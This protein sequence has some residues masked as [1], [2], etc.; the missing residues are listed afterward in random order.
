MDTLTPGARYW[1]TQGAR[2]DKL[3]LK[4]KH[5]LT[6]KTLIQYILLIWKMLRS[7]K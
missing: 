4:H 2:M 3:A 5:I 6:Y 7:Y 1:V